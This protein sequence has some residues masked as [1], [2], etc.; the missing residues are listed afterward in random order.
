MQQ[1][2]MTVFAGPNGSGK[3]TLTRR[4]MRDLN[5]GTYINADDIASEA[6]EAARRANLAAKRIDFEEPAF[7]E[8]AKRRL[9]CIDAFQDFAFETVFSHESKVELIRQAKKKGFKVVLYFVTTEKSLLNIERVKKRVR[10]G[11]HDVP[12]E[13]IIARYRR[14]MANLTPA[15]LEADE[16][17]LF[18]NSDISM[19]QVGRVIWAK[20]VPPRITIFNPVPR[21]V[22]AWSNSITPLLREAVA[23][24]SGP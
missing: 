14:S 17:T 24:R 1:P 13:K 7:H 19:R 3:S 2:V 16:I 22:L 21:W 15:S 20:G 23:R 9:G 12:I 4:M 11:G 10:E 6:F 18:D 8:A 5:L